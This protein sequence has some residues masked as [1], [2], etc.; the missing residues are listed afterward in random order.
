MILYLSYPMS[1]H[2]K[3]GIPRATQVAMS[4]RNQGADLVVPHEIMHGGDRHENPAY[5]HADYIRE[6]IRLGLSRCDG[7]ALC[8]GWVWSKGCRAELDWALAHLR[9]VFFVQVTPWSTDPHAL[10]VPMDGRHRING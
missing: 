10:L 8:D 4:L 7:I 9:R 2:H 3:H 5:T 1:G 6:D